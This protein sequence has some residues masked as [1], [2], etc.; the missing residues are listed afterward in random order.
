M[1]DEQ[2]I[3]SSLVECS[4]NAATINDKNTDVENTDFDDTAITTNNC[5]SIDPNNEDCLSQS[6]LNLTRSQ[7]SLKVVLRFFFFF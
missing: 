5:T 3:P 7:G 1:L 2:I 4:V 6:P